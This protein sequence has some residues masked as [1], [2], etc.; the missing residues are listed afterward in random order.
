MVNIVSLTAVDPGFLTVVD[1]TKKSFMIYPLSTECVGGLHKS[2]L[3]DAVLVF[4]TSEAKLREAMKMF[5]GYREGGA[6]LLGNLPPG[7][8]QRKG[9]L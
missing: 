6:K 9:T 1:K 2:F 5:P 3:D 7:S 8:F 4:G